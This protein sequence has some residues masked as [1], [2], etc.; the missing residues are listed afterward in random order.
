MTWQDQLSQF[1]SMFPSVQKIV[2]LIG[3]EGEDAVTAGTSLALSLEKAGKEVTIY[4]PQ[5]P[6]EK[7]AFLA[8]K[9][10]IQDNFGQKDMTITFDY[11]I[12]GIDN[13]ISVPGEDKLSLKVEIKPDFPPIAENQV[14]IST[15]KNSFDLGV[16]VGEESY[17]PDFQKVVPGG[18]WVWLGRQNEQKEWAKVNLSDF[19]GASYCEVVARI[20]Q[21]L[22]LPLDREIAGNLFE[23][24]KKATASFEN[25][26][27]YQTLEIAA[28]CY[29]IYQ[30]GGS[31]P[32]IKK[33]NE[34]NGEKKIF[35]K[36]T[37]A[38]GLPTPRIFKGATTPRV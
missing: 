16:V 38:N 28:L 15:P 4:A 21:S 19:N 2:V 20:I 10:K 29:K 1:N 18:N 17:F 31:Q 14:I 9:E 27:G 25:L 13:V 36:E 34:N 6:D 35:K 11:P 7:L 5:K 37:K 12:E 32:E 33:D 30:G 8:G 22:G 26:A 23:G 24:I 3:G